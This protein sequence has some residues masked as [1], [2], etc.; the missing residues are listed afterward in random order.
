MFHAVG[1]MASSTSRLAHPADRAAE[2]HRLAT[3]VEV[4]DVNELQRAL[5]ASA[6]VV[7]V[8]SRNLRTLFQGVL[9]GRLNGRLV[10]HVRAKIIGQC[11]R[12]LIGERQQIEEIQLGALDGIVRDG[13]VL[14]L[15]GKLGIEPC[16]GQVVA[17]LV[18]CQGDLPTRWRRPG[19]TPSRASADSS[20][21]QWSSSRRSRA[22]RSARTRMPRW[23]TRWRA[24]YAG[25]A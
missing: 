24:R 6:T 3:L 11:D 2:A 23:A 15:V 20:P 25:T 19:K 14:S 21:A 13:C 8:N 7:G 22:P 12:C 1:L 17:G 16:E 9:D 4:H 18:V 10:E 5:D